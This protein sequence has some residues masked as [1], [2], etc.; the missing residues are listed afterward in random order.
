MLV[1]SRIMNVNRKP[2][3]CPICGERVVDIIYG[4]R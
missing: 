2:T 4:L 3:K 1:R